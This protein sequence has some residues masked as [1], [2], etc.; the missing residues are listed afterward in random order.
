MRELPFTGSDRRGR[1]LGI[2]GFTG[3]RPMWSRKRGTV[4]ADARGRAIALRALH[5]PAGSAD[6][7]SSAT[8]K[9]RLAW[10]LSG[11]LR[12]R[13]RPSLADHRVQR[14]SA[15]HWRRRCNRRRTV[16][17]RIV[18]SWRFDLR[19]WPHRPRLFGC[20]NFDR[21]KW[22]R[23]PPKHL[24]LHC[25]KRRPPRGGVGLYY[26][27]DDLCAMSDLAHE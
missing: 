21:W 15:V 5:S 7:N 18:K 14:T 1:L 27:S 25:N 20:S 2:Y 24:V 12:W 13:D 10:S 11:T 6:G 3:W 17:P 26:Y 19:P 22:T 9:W 4:C 8:A 23:L 16:G